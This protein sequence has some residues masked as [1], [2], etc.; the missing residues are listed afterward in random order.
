MYLRTE[1]V[2][3]LIRYNIKEMK[4]SG[5]EKGVLWYVHVCYQ[6]NEQT[7]EA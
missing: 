4:W 7:F 6:L 1:K 5:R 2:R 3:M